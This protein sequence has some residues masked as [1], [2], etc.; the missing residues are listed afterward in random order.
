MWSKQQYVLSQMALVE[1]TESKKS[2]HSAIFDILKCVS[3]RNLPTTK[4]STSSLPAQPL[5][6][7]V[8]ETTRSITELVL[9]ILNLLLHL[10]KMLE[11]VL[12]AVVVDHLNQLF[13]EATID[14]FPKNEV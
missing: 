12:D 8:L 5:L 3:R 1:V 2:F 14:K 11:L 6:E 4:P 10:R 7:L 13:G 9:I